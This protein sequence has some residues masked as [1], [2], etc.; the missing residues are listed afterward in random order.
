MTTAIIMMVNKKAHVMDIAAH[1][2]ITTGDFGEAFS[3]SSL[4]ILILLFAS[5]GDFQ[6]SSILSNSVEL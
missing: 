3:G 6:I 5:S 2:F 1:R 4:S